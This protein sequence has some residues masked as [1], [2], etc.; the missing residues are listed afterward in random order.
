MKSN[1]KSRDEHIT[2]LGGGPAGLAVGYYAK[3]KGLPFTI[4]EASNRIGGNCITF[5]HG[6]FLF[7][8]GAHRFHDKDAEAT[9]EIKDLIGKDLKKVDLP[10]KIYHNGKFLDF[11]LLPLNLIQKL[12]WLNF[13]KMSADVIRY[14]LITKREN[15]SFE[16]F[17]LSAY[18]KTMANLFLLNYSTKLWGRPCD[19]LS[20][21]INGN[22]MKE[23]NLRTFLIEAVFGNKTKHLDDSFYYPKRGIGTISD[24]LGE[25]C[26]K[27]RILKNSQVTKIVHN[28]SQINAI[29]VNGKNRI[30]T[31]KVVS[32][33]PLGF[34][35]QMM[36][37]KPPANILLIARSLYYRNIILAAF[38]LDD[39]SV[40]KDATVYFPNSNLPFTRVYEP[41]NRS[42]YMSPKG[43]T[44]L[45]IEIPCK[46]GDNF[47]NLED[48]KLIQLILSQLT[49]MGLIREDS[50]LG[51]TVKRMHHCYPIL[52]LGLEE[53]VQ[54]INEFLKEFK[55]LEIAGRNG[56]FV[57]SWIHNMMQFGKE[58]IEKYETP[59]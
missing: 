3:K 7:D 1:K 52:E 23:L 28:N 10:N 36:D 32:T 50:I 40:T 54:K 34:F 14:K 19:K 47:W 11:P 56:K 25:F 18:G 45:V 2:I 8:S 39:D 16:S 13:A 44:S 49:Q 15:A 46:K 9:K 41:K 43:K 33:L 30:K 26:G 6:N 42:V 29:E 55:N 53:K 48:S 31:D 35:L 5:K 57:Y 27:K 17:A 21:N 24:K 37:P 12:G 38:F 58:I 51:S 59:E 22:R 20:A 4:Y